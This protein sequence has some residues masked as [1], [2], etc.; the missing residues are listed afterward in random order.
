MSFVHEDSLDKNCFRIAQ[1]LD[2]LVEQDKLEV[3]ICDCCASEV[4]ITNI[5]ASKNR[6]KI[7]IEV[8]NED[9]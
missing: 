8:D 3:V 4:K 5:V 1:A 9:R 7:L 6:L 2:R